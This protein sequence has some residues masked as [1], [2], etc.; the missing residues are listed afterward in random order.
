MNYM[1]YVSFVY[2]DRRGNQQFGSTIYPMGE[3]ITHEL[4][5]KSLSQMLRMYYNTNHLRVLAFSPMKVSISNDKLKEICTQCVIA[6]LAGK[7]WR[8]K[9]KARQVMCNESECS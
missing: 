3:A 5:I 9:L 8:Q 4:D 6:L 7:R 2:L 1:Y